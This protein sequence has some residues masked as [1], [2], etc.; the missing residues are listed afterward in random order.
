M[1]SS[2]GLMYML[3]GIGSIIGPPIVGATYDA[4]GSFDTGFYIAGGF[5]VVATICNLAAQ[6]IHRK[7]RLQSNSKNENNPVSYSNPIE[8]SEE[9]TL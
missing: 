8:V 1:T 3:Q 6:A 5:F 9:A 2:L 4:I 7:R